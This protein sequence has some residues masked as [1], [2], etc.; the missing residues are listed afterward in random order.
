MTGS[1]RGLWLV[2]AG[3]MILSFDSLLVKLIDSSDWDLLFWR[4]AI[5]ACSLLLFQLV[6]NRDELLA[7][8][9][10][11]TRLMLLAG[12]A[13]AASTVCFVESLS[14]TQVAS[15]LVILNTAPLFTAVLALLAL[16]EKI[17][18]STVLAIGVAISGIWIIFAFAPAKGE[19][20]GN[21]FA[22]F[23]AIS[24]ACYLVILR[25]TQGQQAANILLVSGLMIACY[26]FYKGAQPLAINGD[27]FLL[28]ILLGGVVV[29]GAFLCVS[30][31][32]AY[33]AAAQTSLILLAEVLLG[34]LYVYL[35][36]GDV[37][38]NNDILG[39]AIIL[40]TLALHTIWQAKHAG[41][42]A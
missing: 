3:V 1:Q 33:I 11:P 22:V 35:I 4:G 34:P 39:G 28:L 26:A 6:F 19:L 10:R 20:T 25:K 5:M 14:H 29:P 12:V 42:D 32:A 36:I 37:P 38:S 27:Q 2:F 8:L 13:F 7:G 41:T 18:K 21:I 23:A 9:A 30:W 16:K 17:E 31:S 24:T 40:T 15:T